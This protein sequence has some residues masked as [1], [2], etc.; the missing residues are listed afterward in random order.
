[1]PYSHCELYADA[2]QVWHSGRGLFGSGRLIG[3]NLVLTARHVVTTDGIAE[4]V[5]E[6]WQVRLGADFPDSSQADQGVWIKAS[7]AWVGHNTLDLALLKLHPLENAPDFYPKLKLRIGRIDEVQHRTVR[8]IGFPRGAK[9][10][11]NRMLFVP[12]G[13][14]DDEKGA[15]LSFGIDQAYQPES[16]DKDWRGF[17]GGAV[18][19]A[20]SPDPEAVWIYG[21]AQQVPQSFTNRLAVARLAKAWDDESFRNLLK[22]ASGTLEAPVD[23]ITLSRQGKHLN[24]FGFSDICKRQT[25]EQLRQLEQTKRYAKSLYVSRPS[26]EEPLKRFLESDKRIMPVIGQ[27]GTGKTFFIANTAAANSSAVPTVLL[28]AYRLSK[29]I[30][31]IAAAVSKELSRVEPKL[32]SIH[33]FPSLKTLQ[34]RKGDLLVLLDGLNEIPMA[35]DSVR[36]WL[37]SS[38]NWL[39]DEEVRLIL[40]CRPEYWNLVSD[41]VS[42]E[43]LYLD[44]FSGVVDVHADAPSSKPF[45]QIDDFNDVEASHAR[46]LYGFTLGEV[47]QSIFRHPLLFRIYREAP[48]PTQPGQ[49]NIYDLFS[50]YVRE[51]ANRTRAL[52]VP[53]PSEI[54]F[55]LK[56]QEI[57]DVLRKRKTLWFEGNAFFDIFLG[58][59]SLADALLAEHLLV[60]GEHGLRFA[61][62]EIAYYFVA[63]SSG[64]NLENAGALDDWRDLRENDPILWEATPL[65]LCRFEGEGKL[66]SVRK[67]LDTLACSVHNDEFDSKIFR[68]SYDEHRLFLRSIQWLR[69]PSVFYKAIRTFAEN[70]A[71]GTNADLQRFHPL[72]PLCSLPGLRQDQRFELLRVIA[73]RENDLGWRFTD[74]ETLSEEDFWSDPDRDMSHKNRLKAFVRHEIETKGESAI[75]RFLE[76]LDSAKKLRT[77]S[78]PSGA[79]VGDLAC[80]ILFHSGSKWVRHIADTLATKIDKDASSK[81]RRLLRNMAQRRQLE[82]AAVLEAW[83]DIAG[84]RYDTVIPEVASDLL[85]SKP[86][87]EVI[88]RLTHLL[89]SLLKETQSPVVEA[90][91]LEPLSLIPSR[92]AQALDLAEKLTASSTWIFNKSVLLRLSKHDLERVLRTLK[93]IIES[94]SDSA[95]RDAAVGVLSRIDLSEKAAADVLALLMIYLDK[96]P[97]LHGQL[98]FAVEH[99]IGEMGSDPE[100]EEQI[101]TS[102]RTIWRFY[103]AA[104]RKPI[105]Y[106]VLNRAQRSSAFLGPL[107]T[108]V[109]LENEESNLLRLLQGIPQARIP[110]FQELD[111]EESDLHLRIPAADAFALVQAVALKLSTRP[112]ANCLLFAAWESEEFAKYLAGWI[113]NSGSD[114]S[115]EFV[116]FREAVSSGEK[117]D[118]AAYRIWV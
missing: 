52:M 99:A 9:V 15:T 89:D 58:D 78:P 47:D 77:Y 14:L 26:V 24:W 45:V 68:K 67:V 36:H 111:N 65:V 16:P 85:N 90:A 63:A 6:D 34:G 73:A 109:E 10:D 116:K 62:D 98:G 79:T 7:V 4:L 1:M 49:E 86:N 13:D 93:L 82:M 75:D 33:P 30:E 28:L 19:L 69:N 108:I 115:P 113:A 21:V 104:T 84:D 37:E 50:R 25:Q 32:L 12:S 39:R 56:C 76:W 2:A 72:L 66:D 59:R 101:L 100:A 60:E 117:A 74:W 18:V 61:F 95:K 29:D 22:T 103:D 91:I 55:R 53:V 51:I 23:P 17:S 118:D 48:P 8:G 71:K 42:S 114:R 107:R 87:A 40:S 105:I 110:A 97:E 35:P 41:F 44:P 83:A 31:D 54:F 88:D 94:N 3:R 81:A 102:V 20:E 112:M 46:T 11:N 92:A 57:A 43:L 106:A 38:C 70:C 80:A 27:T 96:Y 5:K 64:A